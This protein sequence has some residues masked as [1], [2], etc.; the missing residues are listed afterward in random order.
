MVTG[1]DKAHKELAIMKKV[2]HP[3]VVSLY[4]VIDDV[5]GDG[6]YFGK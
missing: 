5:N 6:L 3:N 1:L 4:E 2:R